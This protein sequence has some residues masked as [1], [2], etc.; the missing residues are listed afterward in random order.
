MFFMGLEEDVNRL[1]ENES[2]RHNALIMCTEKSNP[3]VYMTR[4][5]ESIG[6]NAGTTKE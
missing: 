4:F 1:L 5:R 6:G 2:V 3:D